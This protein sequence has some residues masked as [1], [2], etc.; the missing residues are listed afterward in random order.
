MLGEVEIRVLQIDDRILVLG[1]GKQLR[2]F[3]VPMQL[4]GPASHPGMDPIET[5]NAWVRRRF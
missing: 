5:L 1:M 2:H 3:C 4:E